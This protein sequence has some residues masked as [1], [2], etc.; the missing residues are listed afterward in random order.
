MTALLE[1]NQVSHYYGNVRALHEVT[2]SVD[3]GS[4]GLIGQ[5]GAGKSTL[6]QILLGLIKPSHGTAVVLGRR[7]TRSGVELRGKIGFMP[8]RSAVI[9]GLNGVEYVAL[10]GELSGMP[11]REALRRAHE[12]LSY[13]DMEDVRYRRVDQYSVGITQRLKL[14]ATLVHDPDLLLLDEPTSGLDPE[15]RAAMLGLLSSLA[16]RPGKSLVLASHLLGDIE[17]VCRSAIIL[18]Q[19]QVVGSGLLEEIRQRQQRRY[20]LR[21]QGSG[22]SFIEDLETQG[23]RWQAVEDGKQEARAT[24]PTGWPT[25]HFFAAAQRHSVLLTSLEPEEEDLEAAYLRVIRSPSDVPTQSAT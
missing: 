23:V 6:M 10:A 14:A 15:G 8:E 12:T 21:W 20:R 9:P 2:L 1:L 7:A 16:A 22:S 11:R 25:R 13:L 5:N 3:A 17:R 4:I 24:V 18:N 19:G